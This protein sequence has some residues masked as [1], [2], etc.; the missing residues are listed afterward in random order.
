MNRFTWR[1]R[2]CS[3]FYAE[4]HAWW[5][6]ITNWI[7]PSP[8]SVKF[9]EVFGRSEII[10]V[11][12]DWSVTFIRNA[13]INCDHLDVISGS[14]Y[15]WQTL[16]SSPTFDCISISD[17]MLTVQI[18]ESF[19]THETVL[20]SYQ[21]IFD[22]IQKRERERE[23]VNRDP[24]AFLTTPSKMSFNSKT[25]IYYRQLNFGK[26][27][28]L[29]SQ[30]TYLLWLRRIF[31]LSAFGR[32]TSLQI[33]MIERWIQLAWWKMMTNESV[34]GKTNRLCMHDIGWMRLPVEWGV[35]TTNPLQY[36]IYAMQN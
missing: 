29:L 23:A 24:L 16:I 8:P 35:R 36:E 10:C 22:V 26:Q 13:N 2:K 18:T 12:T 20:C 25:E 30:F 32:K 21:N 9:T 34:L 11:N 33:Q 19:C 1:V 14:L 27:N 15:P 28:P 6:Y 4:A 5:C 31:F 7:E 17:C 3:S